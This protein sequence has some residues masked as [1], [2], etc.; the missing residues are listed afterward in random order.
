MNETDLK[1]RFF[2][3]ANAHFTPQQ[4]DELKK[5]CQELEN[6][7]INKATISTTLYG[8]V[9]MDML[10]NSSYHFPSFIS[11]V[12]RLKDIHLA[13]VMRSKALEEKKAQLKAQF[14]P[15]L[16]SIQKY[17]SSK[18]EK[19]ESGHPE[20][21]GTKVDL[22]TLSYDILTHLGPALIRRENVQEDKVYYEDLKT[23][24]LIIEKKAAPS[25]VVFSYG[26]SKFK[27][28]LESTHLMR[29]IKEDF[30]HYFSNRIPANLEELYNASVEQVK[31]SDQI[32]IHL[33]AR[34]LYT[35]KLI[36]EGNTYEK[37]VPGKSVSLSRKLA[38]FMID[39]LEKML[40]SNLMKGQSKIFFD[41]NDQKYHYVKNAFNHGPISYDP[42]MDAELFGIEYWLPSIKIK[43]D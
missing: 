42:I 29:E 10:N 1:K 21:F 16:Q 23:I 4:M 41:D 27:G 2:E 24:K 25:R 39:L 5:E 38:L 28:K 8:Q 9:L 43:L 15:M 13:K 6:N 34:V 7:T 32:L 17:L 14:L 20:L 36:P 3:E 30:T 26:I 40:D 12:R 31:M 19:S 22:N 11:T 37:V 35:H 18:V 33:L